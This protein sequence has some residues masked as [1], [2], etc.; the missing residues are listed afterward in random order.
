[1]PENPY[2]IAIYI[3]SLQMTNHFLTITK[4]DLNLSIL[5]E[6]CD[7]GFKYTLKRNYVVDGVDME[8]I[9]CMMNS[10]GDEV[11]Q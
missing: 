2:L 8:E 10:D 11:I 4:G 1:M 3:A 9:L 5:R 7:T 6:V